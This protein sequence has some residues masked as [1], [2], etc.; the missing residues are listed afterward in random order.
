LKFSA[1]LKVLFTLAA[2]GLISPPVHAGV[3]TVDSW[4]LQQ[5]LESERTKVFLLD[6]R[7]PGEYGQG[8]IPGAV[9]IPM[10]QVPGRLEEI[11]REKKVVVVCAS[12]ARSAAVARFLDGKGYPWVANL[13]GGVFDWSGLGLGLAR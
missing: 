10:T 5:L 1:V 8:H 11:P 12:G 4:Q 13:Q 9:L 6:V 7:T 2:L 3:Q